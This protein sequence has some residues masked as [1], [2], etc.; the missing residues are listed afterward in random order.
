MRRYVQILSQFTSYR[1][2]IGSENDLYYK[3]FIA[4][5]NFINLNRLKVWGYFLVVLVISQ[6]YSD[7]FLGEFW[8][9]GQIGYFMILDIALG[10][11]TCLILF[12]THFRYPKSRENIK[13]L[14]IVFTQAYILFHL[15][16]GSAISIVESSTANGVPTYLL[17][18]FTAATI[19]IVRGFVFFVFLVISLIALFTGLY[20]SGMSFNTIFTQYST[21]VALITMAW[22]I[23]RVLFNT[24]KH[25]FYNTKELELARN[26]LDKT[27]KIRTAELSE[28]NEKLL[29]EIKERKRYEKVLQYEKKRAQEADR[30]KSVFLANM[31]HEIRTP[32]NGILGFGDLIQ[33]QE[34]PSDKRA[35]YLEIINSNSHQLLKI[36]DD[37]MDISMIESNQLKI[38][39][40][41]FS[42][43]ILFPDDVEFFK[44]FMRI[45][46]KEQIELILDG[47]PPNANDRIFS[48]PTRLQ[49]ILYNLL[50]NSIK[51]TEKGY[52]KFGGK[53]DNKFALVYV[54]DTGIGIQPEIGKVIFKAFRQGEE[55]I[56]RSYGGT[57][58]GLSISKGIIEL[59]GGMI[60]IDFSYTKGALFCFSIP[61]EE[62]TS[63]SEA[64]F[65]LK[66]F[67][68]LENKNLLIVDDNKQESSFLADTFKT[69]RANISWIK[70][71][72]LMS[73]STENVPDLVILDSDKDATR[74]RQS[75][76]QLA[77]IYSGIP[78]I[79]IIPDIPGLRTEFDKS[80]GIFILTKPVNIQLLLIK[81][82]EFLNNENE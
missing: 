7:F 2:I 13:P 27:V 48:D 11:V 65:Y 77:D 76:S 8:S 51:F 41:S 35:R 61:T 20:F 63:D 26:S 72:K 36:I 33:N 47:F 49:Q 50:S 71:E 53:I 18:V 78:L 40:I 23:S 81:C 25:T 32:L 69:R 16:W 19:F 9:T 30:L 42:L 59:L 43:S 31:S 12:I 38:N 21:T 58:L 68:I 54:E 45:H 34:L 57:G 6:L 64:F 67:T 52:V 10:I 82:V 66:D 5:V 28:S 1:Y 15:L 22:V 24:R 17:G 73:K 37:L 44:N 29:A 70:Y 3:E 14:Y 80:A 39:K 75:L 56:T 4:D 62:V 46:N 74:L 79:A 55:T 60:W